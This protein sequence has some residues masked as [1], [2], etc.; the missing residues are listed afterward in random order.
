LPSQILYG[1]SLGIPSALS[2]FAT[3]N[4]NVNEYSVQAGMLTRISNPGTATT[5]F[6]YEPNTC[7]NSFIASTETDRISYTA[8]DYGV[9]YGEEI[10]TLSSR[11][12]VEIMVLLMKQNPLVTIGTNVDA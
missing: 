8:T 1:S 12:T 5:S 9:G 7:T 3:A 4:R 10:F 6:V 2:S 11:T